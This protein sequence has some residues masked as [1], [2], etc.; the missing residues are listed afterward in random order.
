MSDQPTGGGT[1]PDPDGIEADAPVLLDDEQIAAEEIEAAKEREADTVHLAL[2]ATFTERLIATF[3]GTSVVVTILAF[4][5]AMVIGGLIIAATEEPVRDALGYF[6]SRPGDTFAAAWTAVSEA[7]AALLRG[8]L[9]GRSQLSETLVS[10]TPLI[11]TGLAVAVPLRA[12]LFNIGA[13][14]QLIAGGLA[15]GFVGF[16][17]TGLPMVVHLPFAAAAGIAAGAAYGWLP[18]L[19]KARTGAHEVITTIMLN[20]I[21]RLVAAYLVSTTLFRRPDR[22]DPISKPVEASAQFPRFFDDLRVNTSLLMALALALAVFWLVERS[23]RG[24]EL[25]AVGM[26]AHAATTAG[27]NPNTT[28]IRA[29]ATGGALAG[30]AGAA[31]ILG[32][33]HRLTIGFSAGL[34]FEGITVALLGRGRIGGTVAAGLLF[35]GLKAGG[36]FMQGQT[37]TSLDLVL[38]IQALIIVFIAAPGLVRAI[39]RIKAEDLAAGQVAKGWGS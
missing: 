11:L 17:V 32:L 30:A 36:R 20:N 12:G 13:E 27:M 5:S 24:F 29:M 3:T 4:L 35:G 26:N 19:L 10:A 7:Y 21:G 37:G 25:N 16:S 34:G 38:V 31:T 15:A 6:T 14:G 23:T 33:Q 2:D 8:S 9:G 22:T 28:V 18:G 1:P 39:F